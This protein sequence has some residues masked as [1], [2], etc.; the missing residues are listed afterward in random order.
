M[1]MAIPAME[2]ILP[3]SSGGNI[4]AFLAKLWKMVNNPEIDHL[5][6]WSIEGKSFIIKD[7]TEF[8]KSLLPYYYKH[9]N[10]ASFVR[11]LNM[12]DFHKV[13]NVEAGGLRGERDEVEFAHPYFERGQD[14]LLEQIK[15]KVSLTTRGVNQNQLVPVNTEKVT[16]VLSEVSILK[17]RQEDLD[18]KLQHMR[19]EN[20]QLWNEVENLRQKHERQQ[21]IVNKLISFLGAMVQGQSPNGLGVGMKRKLKPSISMIQLA[22]EEECSNQK[23]PKVEFPEEPEPHEP[24]I[25]EVIV[26][27]PVITSYSTQTQPNNKQFVNPNSNHVVSNLQNHMEPE[28][29]KVITSH[30][31]PAPAPPNVLTSSIAPSAP[32]FIDMSSSMVPTPTKR[33]VLQRQI[34]KEDFDVD[35]SNIQAELDSFKDT[36]FGQINLDNAMVS[37]LFDAETENVPSFYNPEEGLSLQDNKPGV[38]AEPAK[39]KFGLPPI[40]TTVELDLNT[41]LVQ[42]ESTDPLKA[43]FKRT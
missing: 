12:Y 23:E 31:M 26:P 36:L 37:S 15:R 8:A 27:S 6:C 43:M 39:V 33:P 18:E 41:P 32:V 29:T 19:N 16:E 5:I 9:S 25:T 7:Q 38:T 34:T 13:M 24:I 14:H 17:N 21:R 40:P 28:K 4:P 1:A 35:V 22:L 10:M 42:D 20:S 2:M 3:Q 11:Q 30:R